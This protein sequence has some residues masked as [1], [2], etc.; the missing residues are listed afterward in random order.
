MSKIGVG[1]RIFQVFFDY[2]TERKQNVRLEN[3]KLEKLEVAS[4]VPQGSL[5]GPI[6]LCF[7]INDLLDTLKF[8]EPYIFDDDLKILE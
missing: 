8:S 6:L 2:L 7:F 3:I 1:G 5:P 4:G